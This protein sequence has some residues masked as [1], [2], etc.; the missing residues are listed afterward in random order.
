MIEKC[1]KDK[2]IDG[3]R[4]P[5]WPRIVGGITINN[6]AFRDCNIGF[7]F[8]RAF[9]RKITV[10][11]VAVRKT[12]ITGCTVGS[13]ALENIEIEDVSGELTVWGSV[14]KHVKLKGKFDS[15]MLHGIA[16][17][18]MLGSP[19]KASE[20]LS[21]SDQYYASCDWALDISEAE[22][23]DFSI[24]TRGVPV[25][26]LRLDPETQVIVR[27]P[28]IRDGNWIGLVKKN[29]YVDIGFKLWVNEGQ[30]GDLVVV[31]PKRNPL[32]FQEVMTD[33][34]CLRAAGIIDSA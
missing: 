10:K 16:D 13:V 11:N 33:I 21:R 24:R 32:V 27:A 6:C 8:S 14:L 2:A 1:I 20:Y 18:D 28:R 26:L 19:S 12:K 17:V 23:F 9:K 5:W 30:M 29:G 7:G 31:A 25:D 15:W 22:F 4:G 3:Y 34:K